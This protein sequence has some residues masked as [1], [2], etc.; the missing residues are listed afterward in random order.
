MDNEA[1]YGRGARL[2]PPQTMGTSP[3]DAT[4]HEEPRSESAP[5]RK[6]GLAAIDGDLWLT[7][8]NPGSMTQVRRAATAVSTAV[9]ISLFLIACPSYHGYTMRM[10]TAPPAQNERATGIERITDADTQTA[11]EIVADVAAD[12]GLL[13][14]SPQYLP[15]DLSPKPAIVEFNGS[16]DP[17]HPPLNQLQVTIGLFIGADR[18]SIEVRIADWRSPGESALLRSLETELEQRL[19]EAFPGYDIRVEPVDLG[20]WPP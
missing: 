19:R 10:R 3:P 16:G 11:K 7:V 20:S 14:S 2:P 9:S 1:H 6:G 8:C 15:P 4:V 5:P 13:E 17:K 18:S 12:H